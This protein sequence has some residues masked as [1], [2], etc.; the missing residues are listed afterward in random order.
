MPTDTVPTTLV[1]FSD[2]PEASK[3]SNANS[4]SIY[5]NGTSWNEGTQ[6]Y[7]WQ[8]VA[9]SSANKIT[10]SF[11]T[12]DMVLK[13]GGSD[14][15]MATANQN[16]QW[17]VWTGP[18]FDPAADDD[19]NSTN[20]LDE[21]A[22]DWD[23]AQTCAFRAQ[24]VLT[25]F[26]TWE[27]GPDEW[28]KYTG[29]YTAGPVY[30]AFDPPITIKYTHA[31]TASDYYLEYGGFGDLWGIPGKCVDMDTGSDVDCMGSEDN[32]SIRWVPEISI[33]DGT[34]VTDKSSTGTFLDANYYVKALEKESYMTSVSTDTCT[35]AGLSLT[36][37]TLP[38]SSLYKDPNIGTEPAAILAGPP[39]VIDGIIQ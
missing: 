25:T 23:T 32:K 15:V 29:L 18:M 31:A 38:T 35:T 37:Y 30:A 36:S 12:T 3:V 27:T 2:C 20:N 9:P 6:T 16:Y 19:S 33:P 7:D 13:D 8:N 26:Y 34:A 39:K 14:V 28:N 21:M 1:C 22:C 11:S 10:Y 5:Y 24:E 17:G 4:T